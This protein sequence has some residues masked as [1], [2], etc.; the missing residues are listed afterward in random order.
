MLAALGECSLG[1]AAELQFCIADDLLLVGR[2]QKIVVLHGCFGLKLLQHT[3]ERPEKSQEP[4]SKPKRT[5]SLHPQLS[6]PELN[7]KG[8]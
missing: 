7:Q 8:T 3:R 4:K 2:I 1:L 6:S 5:F